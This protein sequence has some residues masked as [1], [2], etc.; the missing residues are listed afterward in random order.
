MY[1]ARPRRKGFGLFTPG[2]PSEC[3]TYGKWIFN[4]DCW[5]YSPSAW[6][7]M[8]MFP[9][10]PA[11][12]PPTGPSTV[13]QETVPGAWTP[14]QAIAGGVAASQQQAIDFFKTV[15]YV[16]DSSGN[17][18][19]PPPSPIPGLSLKALIAIGLVAGGGLLLMTMGGGRRRR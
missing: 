4:P 6:A 11:L 16:P 2:V 5:A 7:Q 17:G 19:K 12:K 18:G 14:D 13:A 8:G 15:P 1:M 9:T 3:D 10:P